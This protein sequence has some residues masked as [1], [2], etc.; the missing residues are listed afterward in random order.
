[1][2]AIRDIN[3]EAARYGVVNQSVAYPYVSTDSTP[4]ARSPI[5]PR[6][7]SSCEIGYARS[8]HRP[9]APDIANAITPRASTIL[10]SIEHHPAQRSAAV[11]VSPDGATPWSARRV[12]TLFRRDRSCTRG[13]YEPWCDSRHFTN[14]LSRASTVSMTWL[15]TYSVDSPRNCAYAYSVSLFSQS[16]RVRC[17]T[18]CL[19]RVRGLINGMESSV[20]EEVTTAA[21]RLAALRARAG[22]PLRDLQAWYV[23]DPR[24]VTLVRTNETRSRG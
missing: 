7:T 6:N 17:F 22:I 15:S 21:T 23:D 8:P 16:S 14:S 1:M 11:A 2:I 5:R 3:S 24:A 4:G 9:T 19:P 20:L 13:T 18:S 12:P 10:R